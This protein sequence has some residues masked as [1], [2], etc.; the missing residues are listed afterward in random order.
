M[1]SINRVASVF[2]HVSTQ[3]HSV[4]NMHS[5]QQ[6]WKGHYGLYY[7][8]LLRIICKTGL[9]LNGPIDGVSEQ[10]GLGWRIVR[11]DNNV[12]D[13]T[14]PSLREW[15]DVSLALATSGCGCLFWKHWLRAW[16]CPKLY[17]LG[18]ES[19]SHIEDFPPWIELQVVIGVLD[20]HPN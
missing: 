2:L 18:P 1:L 12:P 11:N 13:R 14:H 17:C 20:V 4:V 3:R 6:P 19:W 10:P 9:H 7:E 15:C 5:K 8:C 16:A